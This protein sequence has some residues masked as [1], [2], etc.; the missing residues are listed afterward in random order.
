MDV[1]KRNNY[2][3]FISLI[4]IAFIY[5]GIDTGFIDYIFPFSQKSRSTRKINEVL[6]IVN[7]Y[8]VDSVDWQQTGKGAIEGALKTLDPHSVYFSKEEV[9]RND[10]N[11]EGRYH[12]IGIQ[13][14]VIDGYITVIAVIPGSP[15]QDAGLLAGDQIVKINGKSAYNISSS[16]VPKKLKGPANSEVDVTIR[17]EGMRNPF[18]V[19]LTRAEIPIFTINT[20]F[21]PDS[22]TG[23]VWL[24]RF[25]Q[26]TADELEDA[27]LEMERQ[28]IKRLILDLRDNGGGLL[29]QAV[30][31]V[32]KFID[33]H[34]KV[35]YTRGRLSRFNETYYTDE[36]ELTKK[37]DYPLIVLIDQS[38]ASASE[39]VAGALQDYDR[40]LIVG[41][42]SFGK[43]LVQNEFDLGDGS[44]V[45]LTISKYYT[46]SGRLIQRAYKGKDIADYYRG[47]GEDSL[48]AEK[49]TLESPVFYT[50][51][52]RKV[53]GGGGIKPDVEIKYATYAHSRKLIMQLNQKRCFFAA[54]M[55][56]SRNSPQWGADFE[57]F[58]NEFR[59]SK[60]ELN[61]LK[62]IAGDKEIQFKKRD[63]IKDERYLKNRLKAEVAR[64]FWGMPEFYRVLLQYDNQFSEAFN[65]FKEAEKIIA[66]EEVKAQKK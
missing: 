44:R 37:R 42:R 65:Y 2:I 19:T 34:K 32:G 8:Y 43:G 26:H 23:Y 61:S 1:R 7:K 46:P 22:I 31:V 33:G 48:A 4:L 18:D 3:I 30:Q 41:E 10:E 28:G 12:G 24:N 5:S 40:A 36:F 14:D 11:F 38:S 62:K 54:A 49:D 56:I 45:R 59:V 13:F 21:R 25:A 39:I 58:Y 53:F 16:D 9:Q 57:K 35:V 17:R 66:S 50:K 47:A 52:G 64:H 60:S 20:Y 15:A 51:A 6:N 29:R 63:F 27:L 55:L